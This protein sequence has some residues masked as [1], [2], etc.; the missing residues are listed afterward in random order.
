MNSV[1][2]RA[3]LET[4]IWQACDWCEGRGHVAIDGQNEP[5]AIC[6]GHGGWH[7][8]NSVMTDAMIDAT[9]EPEGASKKPGDDGCWIAATGLLLAVVLPLATL[10]LVLWNGGAW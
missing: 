5:C 3:A 9:D 7:T 1:P 4:P 8:Y 2:S 6:D 10:V